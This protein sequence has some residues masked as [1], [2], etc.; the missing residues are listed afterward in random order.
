MESRYSNSSKTVKTR[1]LDEFVAVSGCHR[2]HVIRLLGNKAGNA[3]KTPTNVACGRRIYDEAVKQ[4][5]I[6]MWEAADRIGRFTDGQL[7]TLQRRVRE[8]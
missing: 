3:L 6:V 2:K 4:A 5:L 8:W 7:R 1:I